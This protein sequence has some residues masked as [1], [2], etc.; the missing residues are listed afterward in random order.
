VNH[1]KL[2]ILL[3]FAIMFVA[4]LTIGRAYPTPR[5]PV[6]AAP[7]TQPDAGSG[8]PTIDKQ[9]DLSPTQKLQ[10]EKI[11]KDAHAKTDAL[12]HQFREF[13]RDRD[14]SIK[15]MLD[16]DQQEQYL[17]I[18]HQRDE[19]V[20]ALRAEI[21]TT[22]KAAEKETREL[23]SPDQQKKFDEIVKHGPRHGPP[24]LMMGGGPPHF[25]HHGGPDTEPGDGPDSAPSR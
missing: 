24:P 7:T 17:E 13:D 19:H 11:W 23:L 4:G 16:P 20:N 10:M 3:G 9:L 6:V 12:S 14:G 15:A 18:Q 21:S 8:F 2:F 25:H 1:L 22:M 5:P